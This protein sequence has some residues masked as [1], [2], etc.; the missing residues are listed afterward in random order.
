MLADQFLQFSKW[1]YSNRHQFTA[2][3]FEIETIAI[4]GHKTSGV[5]RE[6]S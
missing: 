6:L 4:F 2:F 1:V 3:V 5:L